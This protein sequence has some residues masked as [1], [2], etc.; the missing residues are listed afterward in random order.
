MKVLFA[1][2]NDKM[3]E[4]IV[5]QYQK[6]YKQ[7]ISYKNVYY[8]NAILK[9]LQRDKTYERIVISEDLEQYVNNDY[10]QMDKF[11]F[12]RLDS[13]SDEASNLNGEDI[14]II[15]ICTGR[16]NKAEQI[17]V[18]LFGIGIYNAILGNDRSVNEVCRLINR[19]RSKKEAKI[20][21]KI[22]SEDVGYEKDSEND[23]SE[24]EIQ[25]ILAH[26]KRIGNDEK[27]YVDSFNSI[28]SQYN[29]V[30]LKIISQCLPLNVKAVLEEK[31]PKYQQV[32]SYN[33]KISDSVRIKKEEKKQGPSEILL[34]NSTNRTFN[35]S[36]VIPSSI[37]TSKKKKIITQSTSTIQDIN[38]NINANLE[39][40]NEEQFK[41][42]EIFDN[43][44]IEQVETTKLDE[45]IIEEKP[46]KRGR[47]RPR[48]IVQ[49]PEV[50]LPKR[51]RGRPRKTEVVSNVQEEQKELENKTILPEV[52][53]QEETVLP[54]F[55]EQEETILPGFDEQEETVLPGFEEQEETVLP[56]FE[57]QEET[58]L[59]GFEEQKETVLPGFEEQ[60]E[61][62]LPVFN[63]QEETEN[64]YTEVLQNLKNENEN[65][66]KTENEEKVYK[67]LNLEDLLTA[68]QKIV[69]FLG[70]SKNG[71][72]FLINNI[73]ELLSSN[74]VDVAVLDL[75]RN[76]NSYYIYTQND[77]ALRQ[78]TNYMISNLIEGK[79]NGIVVHNNLTV[80]TSPIENDENL[81]SVEPII[82]TL[83]R[84]HTLILMDCDFTTPMRYFK[85]AQE[86]YLIQSMDILTIQPLTA[87]LRQ[88]QDKNMFDESKVRVVLN[89]FIRTREINENILIGG[90]SIYNDPGMTVRRELFNRRTV[91]YITIPFEI[92]TY[93]RYLE[94]LVTCDISLKGYSKEFMQSLKRL[95]N[96]IY[97]T[98]KIKEKYN[99]PSVKNNMNG[100][101]SNMND[102]LNQMRRNY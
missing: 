47:G 60:E 99:P 42:E 20:Y 22:D 78:K 52:D 56:G 6:D 23:V 55:D 27:K 54:G 10:E 46:Q 40:E 18:K 50:K 1:V 82:E 94:G 86:I 8:F 25:N 35:E 13:I 98:G 31:S 17:L 74:G 24:V 101:S 7:I 85:Y 80:Y 72:S 61:T 9:E 43:D 88:L 100:F 96:M 65:N 48:K 39:K 51:G 38:R 90:I 71:T 76:R 41:D 67:K 91:Q 19:P 49:E 30:Q 28:A 70:T 29:D 68:N 2:N 44:I 69:S 81:Q 58:V 3:S 26:Y 57:E 73:A 75:T 34:K 16:R 66:L 53:K 95:A 92:K 45:N 4:A 93:L 14:P 15:L 64:K 83:A 97:K 84:N 36:V 79:P 12:D 5:K 11:I 77:E 62:V 59:P 87:F 89:K 33:N 32:N 102:T 63:E 21:Y 37:D